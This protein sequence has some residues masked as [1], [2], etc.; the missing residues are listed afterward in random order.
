MYIII[1]FPHSCWTHSLIFLVFT[2][3]DCCSFNVGSRRLPSLSF[4]PCHCAHTHTHTPYWVNDVFSSSPSPFCGEQ[5]SEGF[6]RQ[7][8]IKACQYSSSLYWFATPSGFVS[9]AW[10]NAHTRAEK[11]TYAHTRALPPR[12]SRI[13]E[14]CHSG[15]FSPS[16][17]LIDTKSEDGRTWAGVG[18]V[19]QD[20]CQRTRLPPYHDERMW[21]LVVG[22]WIL[23]EDL[24]MFSFPFVAWG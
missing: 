13:C 23:T 14:K 24:Y 19:L 5:T 10:L 15:L 2:L 8:L 1:T 18:M 6:D 16:R 9:H 4:S 7:P 3:L 22:E 11:G 21:L 20:C 17:L 12:E